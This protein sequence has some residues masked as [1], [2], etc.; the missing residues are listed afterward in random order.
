MTMGA[1]NPDARL[2][3]YQR[4]AD[5]LR[6]QVVAGHWRPGD[7]LPSE[8]ELAELHELAAGTVRQALAQLVREGILERQHGRGTFVRRPTFDQSLFRFYRLRTASG[9]TSIPESRILGMRRDKAPEYVANQLAIAAGSDAINIQRLR[10]VNDEPVLAEEIWLPADKFLK[11]LDLDTNDIGPLLYPVYDSV[12]G[13]TVAHAQ[14]TLTAE[15]ASDVTAR[16]LRLEQPAPVIVIERIANGFDGTPLEW[17]RSRGNARHFH[18]QT[19][20]R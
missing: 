5:A 13:L 20:I 16:L 19:E 18:Y 11:L 9:E 15:L 14:E 3:L 4:L 6:D 10:L 1:L 17:R 7:R 2:P 12:C 8:N